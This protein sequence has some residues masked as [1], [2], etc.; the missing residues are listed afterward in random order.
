MTS[1]VHHEASD[2]SVP[3][4]LGFGVGLAVSG[5][6]ISLLVGALYLYFSRQAVHRGSTVAGL[7][8]QQPIPP[9]P[10]LQ[11]DP[12][13]DLLELREAED[14]ALTTYGWVD[15]NAGVVRIPIEQAMKLTVARGLPSRTKEPPP[16]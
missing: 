3:G 8:R 6:V 1:S 2:V 10:R 9:S 16:R 14:R 7:T 13:G 12:R 5:L 15:R 4:V 11:T